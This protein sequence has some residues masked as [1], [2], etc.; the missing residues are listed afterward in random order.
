MLNVIFD[1]IQ[2]APLKYLHQVEAG[3]TLVII[4]SNQPI[5]ELKPILPSS[6]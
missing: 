2:R 1:K 3:A 5:A 4:K 6:K